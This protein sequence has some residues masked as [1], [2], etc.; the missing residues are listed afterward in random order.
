MDFDND[1]LVAETSPDL[2]LDLDLDLDEIL[3]NVQPDF[4]RQGLD[5]Y[6]QNKVEESITA[7]QKEIEVNPENANAYNNL[8]FIYYQKSQWKDTIVACQKAIEL[9]PD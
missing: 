9:K 6:Q 7:F 2:D 4:F 3:D 1:D 5:L 8:G